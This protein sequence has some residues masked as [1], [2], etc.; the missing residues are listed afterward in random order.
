MRV[1]FDRRYELVSLTATSSATLSPVSESGQPG[2]G[3]LWKLILPAVH[4]SPDHRLRL[5]NPAKEEELR[6]YLRDDLD[7]DGLNKVHKHLWF[8][9]LPKRA[10]ALHHQLMIGR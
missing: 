6:T 2:S 8:A 4:E 7:V 9:G 3:G 1:P 5:V 10:R